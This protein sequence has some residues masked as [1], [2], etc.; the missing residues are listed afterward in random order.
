MFYLLTYL[1]STDNCVQMMSILIVHQSVTDAL[2]SLFSVIT[3]VVNM[4]IT[5]LSRNSIYDQF[6]C[7]FWITKLPLWSM[8]VTSTYGILL[9]TL[10]RYIAVIYPMK[11]KIVRI[12]KRVM[13][14]LQCYG[15]SV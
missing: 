1:Y 6:F 11:Y 3:T 13:C 5:G 8:L 2:A 14:L 10:S 9:T 7:R 12:S 15:L 4:N